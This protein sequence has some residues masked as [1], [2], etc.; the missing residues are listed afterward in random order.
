M[1]DLNI[2]S[3]KKEQTIHKLVAVHRKTEERYS[4]AMGFC[5]DDYEEIPVI[6]E[7]KRLLDSYNI[8]I[9]D[10]ETHGFKKLMVERTAGYVHKNDAIDEL[11]T[12]KFDGLNSAFRLAL[13]KAVVSIELME[14]SYG[15]KQI[16]AGRK[17]E[18]LKEITPE[19]SGE[20]NGD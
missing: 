8:S 19:G 1:C 17:I 5:Y 18:F 13:F 2:Y 14:G 7:Q 10:S 9:L 15:V 6:T 3:N 12:Y 4:L 20:Q 11:A 16:I